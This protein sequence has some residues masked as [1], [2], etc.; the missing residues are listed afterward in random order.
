[1][2]ELGLVLNFDTTC[3]IEQVLL[4]VLVFVITSSK[5]L[6]IMGSWLILAFSFQA[7]ES[8]ILRVYKEDKYLIITLTHLQKRGQKTKSLGTRG[9]WFLVNSF[10]SF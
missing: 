1:P 7:E 9:S 4:L 2:S 6:I 10:T 5:K 8:I 3:V